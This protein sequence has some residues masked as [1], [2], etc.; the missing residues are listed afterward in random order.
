MAVHQG[1]HCI[2]RQKQSSEKEIQFYLDSITYDPSILF[3]LNNVR[4]VG[5]LYG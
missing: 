4:A 3:I 1:L 5:P 2:L